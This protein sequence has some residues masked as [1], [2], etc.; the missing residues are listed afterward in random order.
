MA[1]MACA[2][3]LKEMLQA[4][5]TPE[6]LEEIEGMLERQ[7]PSIP[8]K[9]IADK[10]DKPVNT[11]KVTT[12]SQVGSF[13][14]VATTTVKGW[15]AESPPM[16]G[17]PGSFDLSLIAK[18]QRSKQ[19]FAIGG[20]N[21]ALKAAEVRL[22]KSK[23]EAQEMQNAQT[24][25]ELVELAEVERAVATILIELR[26]SL[27]SIPETLATSAPPELKQFVRNEAER[28]IVGALT[29]AARQLSEPEYQKKEPDDQ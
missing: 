21:D 23:S 5:E 20:V 6:D 4:A 26:E 7:S 18:W 13:F 16:P 11:F 29:T 9:R 12:L 8:E 19:S 25:G 14:G 17:R 22:K 28:V 15:R 3:T 27:M 1:T 2:K 10:T 24:R